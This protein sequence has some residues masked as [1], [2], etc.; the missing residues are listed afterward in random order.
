MSENRDESGNQAPDNPTPA[1][2][3]LFSGHRSSLVA[4][5]WLF[6]K[7]E[8]KWWLTPIIVVLL[9]L[10]ALLLATNT[11]LGPFIYPLF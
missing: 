11:P 8:K 3:A 7:N 10:A 9:L 6:I 4:E 5:F 1:E 2:E